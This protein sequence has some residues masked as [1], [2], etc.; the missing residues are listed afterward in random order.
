VEDDSCEFCPIV[1]GVDVTTGEFNCYDYVW[2]YGYTVDEMVNIYGFDCTCVTGPT[3]GC[4]IEDAC[5]YNIDAEVINN[6]TCEYPEYGYDC[7]GVCLADGDGDGICD[8]NDSCPDDA[9]DSCAGCT[10]ETATNYDETATVD[11]GSCFT[12]VSC[13]DG[14]SGSYEY[15]NYDETMF[16]YNVD[17]GSQAQVL[18]SGSTESCCDNV[19]VYNGAGELITSFA[20]SFNELVVSDDNGISI[21]FDSDGSVTSGVT[22][23]DLSCVGEGTV[24]GCT[25]ATACNFNSEATDDDA[26]CTY[27]DSGYDCE[28]NLTCAFDLITISYVAASG[29]S[30]ESEN[31]WQILDADG[32]IVWTSTYSTSGVNDPTDVPISPV[33]HDGLSGDF[34][35]DPAGCYTFNLYDT[36]GDGWHG[37]TLD[38]GA[39]GVYTVQAGN[40]S[41]TS[42][43]VAECTDTEVAVFWV[44]D[45]DVDL[46]GFGFSINGTDGPIAS[47]GSDFDGVACL[48]LVGSCYSLALSQAGGGSTGSTV[49]LSIDGMTFTWSDGSDG[50][51][52]SE[53]D[54]AMGS[55]CPVEGCADSTACNYVG[56]D[57]VDNYFG[58]LDCEYPEFG[59]DCEGACEA[60][61]DADGICDQFDLCPYEADDACAGCTDENATNYD[62]TVTVDDGSCYVGFSCA[63]GLASSSGA[64]DSTFSY[65]GDEGSY[66]QA[67]ISGAVGDWD[68]V[69]ISNG[70]GDVLADYQGSWD[71]EDEAFSQVIISNDNGIQIYVDYPT[72]SVSG[73]E[74]V[75]SLSCVQD[76]PGCLDATACNY[77]ESATL[78]N[79][80]CSYADSGYDCEGVC[81]ADTDGD[82]IC[83]DNDSC[84][85]D[86]TDAC[87]GCTD[88]GDTELGTVAACNYD[89]TATVDN[90]LCTYP[91]EGY[92]CEG[93]CLADADGDG[94]CDEF[95]S[96]PD[97]ATDACLGCT[98][99]F[100]C[101]YSDV[102][103]IDNGSCEYPVSGYDCDGELTCEFGFTTVTYVAA[104]ELS[105]E[106]ENSWTISDANGTPLWSDA[107][108]NYIDYDGIS[109]DL[110]LDPDACY[111]FSLSDSFGDGWNGNSLD[112]GEFGSYTIFGGPSFEGSNCVAECTDTEVSVSWILAGDGVG[113]SIFDEDGNVAATGDNSFDGFACLD[114]ANC[115][116]LD[117]VPPSSNS[118][119]LGS[120]AGI[121]IQIGDETFEY[122]EGSNGTWSSI[123][124]NVLGTC[125]VFGCMDDTACNF[126]SEATDDDASC[127]FTSCVGCMDVTACNFNAEA[128]EDDDSCTYATNCVDCDGI[129]YDSDADGVAD[130]DEVAGCTDMMACNYNPDAT[131]DNDSC[132]YTDGVFDCDGV[133]CLADADGDGI[134]DPN[135]VPGCTDSSASNFDSSATDDNG[136]C[137]YL[138]GCTDDTAANYDATATEDDGSCDFGPWDVTSTDC[139]MTVLVAVDTDITVEGVPVTDALWIGAFNGDGLCAG[140]SYVT[141][142]VVNSV[143]VW[144]AE[145]GDV[146]GMATGE[147]ITWAVFY[148]GEEIPALVVNSFGENNYS[149]NGLAGLDVLA[150]SSIYAQSIALNA[151]WNMWSTHISP[152]VYDMGSVFSS[153]VS[154]T[155]IVK[156]ENGSVFWPA[157][158][159]NNIGDIVDGEGYQVK[160]EAAETLTLEGGLVPADTELS[161][162]NGWNMIGYLPLDPMDATVAMDPVVDNMI[163]MKDENGLVFWPQFGLNNIGNMEPGEGYQLK[164]DNAQTFSYESNDMARFG[165]ANPVRTIH[166]DKA[167]NTGSNMIIGLPLY[168][169]SQIPAIGDEIAAYDEAGN[170]VGSAVFEGGHIAMTVWG[171]DSTTDSKEGVVEGETITFKLWHSDMDVEESFE[172]RWDEGSDMYVT[173]GISVAGNIAL[174]GSDSMASYELYQNIPNPFTGK[175]SIKFFVPVDAEVNISIYNMLGEFVS[176]V[177]NDIY[178]VGEHSVVFEGNELGQGTY[179]V[180]MTTENFTTTKSM[181]VVR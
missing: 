28:G 181:N 97:D 46:T 37:N 26:S 145:S 112:A 167:G 58:F 24:F 35:M 152:D 72:W 151:G 78:D 136:T 16:T 50:F 70:A 129:S 156:D 83:D 103:T 57:V 44:T 155:I 84:P 52:S 21:E 38:A 150:A 63:D 34:C 168:A 89:E 17:S 162:D 33:T 108:F 5:N 144:G 45:E 77:D 29:T 116:S 87:L 62:D 30:Y 139:N 64:A 47:G 76:I 124:T 40:Q 137:E 101:N 59:Y 42:N 102:A 31:A 39:F 51:W 3:L 158:G 88:G 110:C 107:A 176:E 74:T 22:T 118:G 60:D 13:A 14:L 20:G 85:E 90:G 113:F 126:N 36:Y 174:T 173:D 104:E 19:N 179:F 61:A 149:C 123:F 56:D 163:I 4:D 175:T 165:Y 130:C 15:V 166:F 114:L 109:A 75:W 55:G 32:N 141:P 160:M 54:Y 66:V 95:D 99:E 41:S 27:P 148:N 154:S 73:L 93:V 49:T 172:V 71:S 91:A 169:W 81:L 164:M 138:S 69:I 48:D 2:N 177:T 98:D 117:M 132:E 68:N 106:T 10:D 170:L 6:S 92:D 127:E 65:Q 128:T 25:D 171:D 161:F 86:A 23:W 80:L 125:P 133:S 111:T 43:C 120:G 18:L 96:C 122:S 9:T 8:A 147:E 100:A 1:G 12:Y 53:F 178:Q 11:D 135:E 131:D 79:G 153:I 180:K 7:D 142:G 159:L 82:G 105:W 119:E 94:I 157:F 67:F 121:T 140:S 134:C 143:A 115:Y 146:N